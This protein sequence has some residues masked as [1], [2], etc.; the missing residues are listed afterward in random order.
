MVGVIVQL[1]LALSRHRR[2][3]GKAVQIGLG[4]T[5]GFAL[6]VATVVLAFLRVPDAARVDLLA[7]ALGLWLV[8][9]V[10]APSFT[11]GPE[12]TGQYFRLHPVP[13]STLTRGLFAAA[14]TGLPAIVTL[15]AFGVLIAVAAPF[16]PAALLVALIAMVLSVA[17]LVIAARLTA[18]WFAAVSRSRLGAAISSVVTAAII[19]VAQHSWLIIIAIVI[20]LDTGVPGTLGVVLRALPSSWGLVAVTAAGE[21]TWGL[22]AAAVAGLVLLGGAL[23]LLWTRVVT[24][25]PIR[26]AVVRPPLRSR[27]PALGCTRKEVLGWLRNPLRVQ[28]LALAL[29]YAIGTCALPLI[30][31]FGG[32]LPFLGIVTMIMGAATSC[33]LYGSDGTA[34]WLLLATPGSERGDVRGRQRAWLLVFGG[35]GAVLTVVGFALHPDPALLPWVLGAFLAVLGG[36]AG[37]SVFLSV[38]A[39]VPT[40]DPHTAKHSPAE[41]G[42]AAGPA[43]L[44][45]FLTLLVAAPTVGVLVAGALTGN[46]VLSWAGVALGLVT[47]VLVPKL[48]GGAA[49]RRLTVR[50]PELLHRMQS[51]PQRPEAAESAGATTRAALRESF[52]GQPEAASA[53]GEGNAGPAAVSGFEAMRPAE[54]LTFWALYIAAVLAVVPQGLVAGGHLLAGSGT[55]SWFVA[56]RVA[57]GLQWLVV[58]GFFLL[59]AVL[60]ALATVIYSRA[61]RR[62]QRR[63]VAT[64][65]TQ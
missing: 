60:A 28:D 57:E 12:L 47:A 20:H 42:D 65:D 31:D 15:V 19:V 35:L 38:Y 58:G 21:G 59:G 16:G 39:P 26:G 61:K 33:N 34:L 40:Q 51:G 22:A 18:I 29:A 44:A 48:L 49:I 43:F 52:G 14:W 24:S 7:V 6:A 50:G 2:T 25:A 37:L 23:Y 17:V 45:I 1:H 62:E 3:G 4:A 27:T 56:L 30:V 63:R 32:L 10:V 11:G 9:W 55:T 8:G 13:R 54:A 64:A 41:Q 36:G 53:V 5:L 46:N